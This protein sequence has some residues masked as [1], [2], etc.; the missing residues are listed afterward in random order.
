MV[1][2]SAV[3]AVKA[4]SRII[5]ERFPVKRVILYGSFARGTQR[6]DSDIDVA[7]VLS[8]PPE[9]FLKAETELF[10]LCRDIDLRL[11]PVIVDEEHDPS[12]FYQDILRHGMLVYSMP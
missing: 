4:F 9:D 3:E 7:V 12:G 11:E 2:Q 8:T 10:R 6:P 1:A 5:R